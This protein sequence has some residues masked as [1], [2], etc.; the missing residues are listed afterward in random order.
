M[1]RICKNFGL[2]GSVFVS[3]ENTKFAKQICVHNFI[4]GVKD[5]ELQAEC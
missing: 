2:I 4:D 5:H 1:G 3:E